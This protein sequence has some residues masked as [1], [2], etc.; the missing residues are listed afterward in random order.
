[1][2]AQ[3]AVPSSTIWKGGRGPLTTTQ[4]RK[5]HSIISYLSGHGVYGQ[6]ESVMLSAQQQRPPTFTFSLLPGRRLQIYHALRHQVLDWYTMYSNLLQKYFKLITPGH[7]NAVLFVSA[8][9]DWSCCPPVSGLS[10][11]SH[12]SVS[13]SISSINICIRYEHT[14][15]TTILFMLS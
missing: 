10:S 11:V 3:R 9:I 2:P 4:S 5:D 7:K 14:V 13:F 8:F 12:W 6:K 1:M 15:I